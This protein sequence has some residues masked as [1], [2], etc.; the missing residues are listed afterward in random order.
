MGVACTNSLAEV[1]TAREN[2][3]LACNISLTGQ[4]VLRRRERRVEGGEIWVGVADSQL[5]EKSDVPV[6]MVRS[7]LQLPSQETSGLLLLAFCHQESRQTAGCVEP[8]L[9]E[10][11]C[12]PCHQHLPDGYIVS[13]TTPKKFSTQLTAFSSCSLAS[14][15]QEV[16]SLSR[17][18]SLSRTLAS[19]RG[20]G[21]RASTASRQRT[22]SHTARGLWLMKNSDMA[23]RAV[24]VGL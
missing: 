8:H 3:Q 23:S 5:Q 22:A 4:E 13:S 11:A 1:S 24:T 10:V 9:L 17:S 2:T 7:S 15:A 16:C 19:T 20:T 12:R 18:P 21:C 6:G 14:R